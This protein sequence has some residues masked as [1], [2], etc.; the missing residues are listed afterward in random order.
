MGISWVLGGYADWVALFKEASK[1]LFLSQGEEEAWQLL[2]KSRFI[3]RHLAPFLQ[4]SLSHDM[5]SLLS[6]SPNSSVINTLASTEKAGRGTD[7]TLVVRDEVAYHPYAKQNYSSIR[8]SIDSGGQLIDTST[9]N[10]FDA[11]SHFTSR[12]NEALDGAEKIVLPSGLEYWTGGK[13]GAV[14]IF[15]GWKLRPV[16]EEGMTLDEW[17]ASNILPNYDLME[18]ESEY[19]A[20]IEEAMSAP[21]TACRFD[22]DALNAMMLETIPPIREEQNGLIKIYKEPI[23][24]RHYS[25]VVDPAEGVEDPTAGAIID[26]RTDETAL[27]IEGKIPIN[28][29]ARIIYDLWLQYY[30]PYMVPERNSSGM[31]LCERLKD[32]NINTFHYYDKNKTKIGWWTSQAT[33]PVMITDLAEA[34][35]CRQLR[36][37][38]EKMINQFRTFVRTE[39]NPDGVAIKGKHDDWVMVYAIYW[40]T[41]RHVP[42]GDIKIRSYT[43]NE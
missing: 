38:Q 16:R 17:W 6:F 1:I 33:R 12:I 22:S 40:Q 30:K 35:R 20:T 32:M 34:I 15:L 11:D 4:Y 3:H 5:R 24:G 7:A 23:P 13:T 27:T 29:A 37:P 36:L 25:F 28:E 18:R 21:K 26:W 10:K 43:Y 14:V 2:D 31:V 19:P 8:P 9:I 39:R 41:K 42:T